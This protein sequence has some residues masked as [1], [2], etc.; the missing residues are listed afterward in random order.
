MR[1]SRT[2]RSWV[3]DVDLVEAICKRI[4]YKVEFRSCPW[5]AIIDGVDGPF[6]MA[7]SAITITEGR[8]PM[9]DF[10]D[11]YVN[12]NDGLI[13]AADSPISSTDDLGA[14]DTIAVGLDYSGDVWATAELEPRG[15]IVNRYEDIMAAFEALKAG[16]VDGVIMDISQTQ[17][18]LFHDRS[19]D[20]K[21][22]QEIAGP[23]YPQDN[24]LAFAFPKGSA[25][26]EVVNGGL[27]EVMDD[28]TYAKIYR[29][30]FGAEPWPLP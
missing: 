25:L 18:V 26:V 20:A 27:Q 5:D 23:P 19:S 15:V 21:I 9:I 24:L 7:A 10:S 17:Y 4:G 12:A 22:V 28:G 13:V 16:A 8:K 3:F 30:W 1:C 14:G 29:K 11:P 2:T 6:D